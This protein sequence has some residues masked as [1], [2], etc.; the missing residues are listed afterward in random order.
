MSNVRS[1]LSKLRAGIVGSIVKFG[2][3]GLVGFII[4]VGIFNFLRYLEISGGREEWWTTALGAKVVSTSIAIVF[5]WLGNRYW[6][7]RKNRTSPV[8]RELVEFVVASVAGM[9]VALAC[10]W[11]SHYVLGL[12]DIVSDN[13]SGNVIGLGLGTAVRFVLYRYWVFNPNR[14]KEKEKTGE[15][16]NA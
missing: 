11:F 14:G 8:L 12:R 7:F 4:D 2:I 9:L 6:T 3:V 13:I 10:L 5:N 16:V 1:I 15:R